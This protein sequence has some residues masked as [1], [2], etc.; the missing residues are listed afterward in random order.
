MNIEV[1]TK[2]SLFQDIIG[3][4]IGAII[5]G[6]FAILVF[7]FGIKHE[8]RKEQ[9]KTINEL[10]NHLDYLR[11]SIEGIVEKITE[12]ADFIDKFIL[13]FNEKNFLR[14]ELTTSQN[15]NSKSLRA[16][17]L[18]EIKKAFLL[19]P[20][21]GE[22]SFHKFIECT[23]SLDS[24]S[25]SMGIYFNLFSS[26]FRRVQN[27]YNEGITGIQN[28][29][30]DYKRFLIIN[31]IDITSDQ[32][33]LFWTKLLTD[34]NSQDDDGSN[35][36]KT[37]PY[38]TLQYLVMPLKENLSKIDLSY[39]TTLRFNIRRCLS[40]IEDFEHQQ[41]EFTEMFSGLSK[42]YKKLSQKFELIKNCL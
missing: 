18:T 27:Y 7:Y 10:K 24:I 21:L 23:D 40:A 42:S 33:V 22:K 32:L 11:I 8:R 26:E 13:K 6:I 1:F 9:K 30:E 36:K 19:K 4:V 31:H 14:K 5:S 16:V 28:T 25:E 34:W 12:Q 37:D 3:S 41:K 35:L 29:I 38:C 17:P 15:T 2:G 20:E 39:N